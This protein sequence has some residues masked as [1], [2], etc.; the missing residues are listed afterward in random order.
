VSE[1]YELSIPVD[2]LI[3]PACGDH[4]W[5]GGDIEVEGDP[6]FDEIALAVGMEIASRNEEVIIAHYQDRHRLRYWLWMRTSWKW[7]LG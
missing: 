6:D 5:A 3:C 1:T 4:L 7:V 2:V